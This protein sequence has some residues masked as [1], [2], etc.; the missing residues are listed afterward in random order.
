MHQTT[1]LRALPRRGKIISDQ[2]TYLNPPMMRSLTFKTNWLRVIKRFLVWFYAAMYFLIMVV[3]DGLRGRNS[4]EHRAIRL[5]R[6]LEKMGGTMVKIGQQ[7]SLRVDVLPY[8]YCKEL[9]KMLDTMPPFSTEWAIQRIEKASGKVIKEVFSAFDPKPIGSASI[10]CVYQATLLNGKKVAIKVRRPEVGKKFA[11][12]FRA[13]DLVGSLLELATILR[14]GF[15]RTL[16]K[17][18]REALMEELDFTKEARYQELFRRSAKVAGT[19]FV[20]APRVHFKLSSDDVIVMNFAEGIPLTEI[21]AAVEQKDPQALATMKKLNIKRK[22]VARRLLWVNHAAMISDLFFHSDPNPANVL[23]RADS[24]LTFIDFGSCGSFSRS[25]KRYLKEI[26][27]YQMQGDPEGMARASV[28]MLEPLPPIDVDEFS[29]ELE[30]LYRSSVY[31]MESKHSEWWER[32]TA[33]QWFAFMK[34]SMK[35]NVPLPDGVLHFVRATLLYDTVAA[36]LD[37]KIVFYN[38]FRRYERFAGKK[39]RERAKKKFKRSLFQGIDP[40]IY[41]RA[42]RLMDTGNR[43]FFRLQRFIEA[44]PL[45]FIYSLNKGIYVAHTILHTIINVVLGTL[46]I[47]LLIAAY[48]AIVNGNDFDFRQSFESVYNH[49]YYLIF[50]VVMA[51]F[52]LRKILFRLNDKDV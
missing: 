7:L 25:Q 2:E 27:Y 47:T 35:F 43:M 12:D 15:T 3:I 40:T 52:G 28:A 16:R 14:P 22:K 30:S 34:A 48:N 20:R 45:R 6:T 26:N 41:L 33:V 44:P 13:I 24:K 42:S 38:E 23:V 51:I 5:R 21:I 10:A 50:L 4:Q 49:R 8:T 31:A 17:S 46:L 36:R 9:T 32:T 1:V 19:R 29:K 18:L 11:A 37:K 39:I